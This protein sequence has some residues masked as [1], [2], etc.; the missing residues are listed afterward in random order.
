MSTRA[1]RLGVGVPI[2]LGDMLVIFS[3]LFMLVSIEESQVAQ[4]KRM[5]S[6][7]LGTGGE[8]GGI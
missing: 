4:Y 5:G 2:I 8:V 1:C 3:C 6:V 7:M